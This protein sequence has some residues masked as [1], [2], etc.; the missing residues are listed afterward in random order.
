MACVSNIVRHR[1][2]TSENGYVLTCDYAQACKRYDQ[3]HAI[4][5]HSEC[6]D[7]PAGC[8]SCDST[9]IWRS[10]ACFYT[11]GQHFAN[12]GEPEADEGANS[13]RDDTW[14]G[15]PSHNSCA[16][17]I[18]HLGRDRVHAGGYPSSTPHGRHDPRN[19]Q[20]VRCQCDC[21]P[22]VVGGRT[23]WY[24]PARPVFRSGRFLI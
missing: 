15:L 17:R 24:A 10:T 19:L 18:Q 14:Q 23:A 21:T 4:K 1:H 8:P 7:L 22:I 5:S 2:D 11:Q 13:T 9:R 3:T 16:G 12:G 6:H 20:P